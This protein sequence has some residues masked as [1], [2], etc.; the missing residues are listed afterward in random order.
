MDNTQVLQEQQYQ[1]SYDSPVTINVP[2]EIEGDM[3]FVILLENDDTTTDSCTRYRIQDAYHAQ[4]IIINPLDDKNITL[5]NKMLVL[6]TYKLEYLLLLEYKLFP[7][8]NGVRN[9]SVKI[10]FRKK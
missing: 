9:I 2:D 3:E 4:I 10:M 6:G 5:K 8:V 7:I 1:I